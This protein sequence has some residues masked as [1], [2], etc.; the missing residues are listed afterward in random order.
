VLAGYR[1]RW[2]YL[3]VDEHQDTNPLQE[4]LLRLNVHA[5]LRLTMAALPAM[6]QR[7]SGG[8]INVSSVAGFT[9]AHAGSTYSAS[10]AWVTNFSQ[11]IAHAVR[12]HGVRVMALC[13]GLVRT[14]FHRRAGIDLSGTP[15]RWWLS[16]D[17]VAAD[18]LRS[19]ARGKI[20]RVVD[21]RYRM[22]VAGLRVTPGALV[23]AISRGGVAAGRRHR[24]LYV[25]LIGMTCVSS[26]LTWQ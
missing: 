25:W 18:G 7:R 8:V 19:L 21:W 11:S 26:S 16:A 1:R 10:K 17:Q 20:V 4:R 14:E 5:V 3:Q 9:A 12:P 23:R 24:T 22:L 15:Q 6:V 2:R 13:P